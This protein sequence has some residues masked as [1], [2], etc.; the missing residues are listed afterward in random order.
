MV[1]GL[2]R[3]GGLSREAAVAAGVQLMRT[4]NISHVFDERGFTDSKQQHYHFS[5]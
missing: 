2:V 1:D 5:R 4:G 3:A